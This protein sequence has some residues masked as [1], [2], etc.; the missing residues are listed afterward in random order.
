MRYCIAMDLFWSFVLN[1]DDFFGVVAGLGL[2]GLGL[3][4]SR[5]S[6][7][8]SEK[9]FVGL[10]VGGGEL[11]LLDWFTFSFFPQGQV[12]IPPVDVVSIFPH[13]GHVTFSI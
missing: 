4:I 2:S 5:S 6:K 9:R 7:S 1:V 11:G 13:F 10:G 12:T 3:G 8:A